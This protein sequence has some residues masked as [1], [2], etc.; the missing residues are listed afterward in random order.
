MIDMERTGHYD[1][2]PTRAVY[3]NDVGHAFD[4]TGED[5]LFRHLTLTLRPRRVYA[6]V[7]PSGSGKSTLLS[8]IAGW[9]KPYAGDVSRVDCGRVTWVLQNPHGAARRTALDHVSLPFIAQGECRRDADFHARELMDAFGLEEAADKPF[10][11]LSGG[12]AQRLMLAR[13]IA[14]GAGL[15]L[16]DEPTAQLDLSTAITVNERLNNLSMS[17]A[18]VVVATHDP[19][20]RDACT[21]LIDLRDY[22]SDDCMD[23]F[24]SDSAEKVPA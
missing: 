22:Q 16:V 20:T 10:K 18:I 6:L 9:T 8:I 5:M 17:G 11:D 14:S 13:G 23:A 12:E 7:G 1:A 21:D 2:H 15:M 3:L 4:S 19:R 24:K